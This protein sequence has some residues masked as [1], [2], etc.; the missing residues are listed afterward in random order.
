MSINIYKKIMKGRELKNFFDIPEA[1]IGKELEIT[2]KPVE[3]KTFQSLSIIQ[4][5]TKNFKFNR[6]EANER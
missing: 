1:F 5:D 4:L 3:E 6:D 2:I